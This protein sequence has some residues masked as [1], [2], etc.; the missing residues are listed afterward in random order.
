VRICV[1]LLQ[2]RADQLHHLIGLAEAREDE[3]LLGFFVIVLDEVLH[4]LGRFRDHLRIEIVVPG[5]APHR[6]LINQQHAIKHAVL[7]HQVFRRRDVL[8]FY[9]GGLPGLCRDA[10]GRRLCDKGSGGGNDAELQQCSSGRRNQGHGQ[11]SKPQ[12]ITETAAQLFPARRPMVYVWRRLF[13]LA[14][15]GHAR[16]IAPH[17]VVAPGVVHQRRGFVVTFADSFGPGAAQCD[18]AIRN[19]LRPARCANP[20]HAPFA[21]LPT[22]AMPP[23]SGRFLMLLVQ[24]PLQ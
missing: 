10:C 24:K 4:H 13:D 15:L 5:K 7:T 19:R 16:A 3:V 18:V 20:P 12:P 2:Q 9:A 23:L 11:F 14:A 17:L 8:G 22:L 21:F 6:R 1:V